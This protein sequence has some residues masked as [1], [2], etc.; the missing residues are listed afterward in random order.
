MA[1]DIV[2]GDS[3]NPLKPP[4]HMGLES[5]KPKCSKNTMLSSSDAPIFVDTT[6]WAPG[7]SKWPI[8]GE[9]VERVCPLESN[10]PSV[11]SWRRYSIIDM[12]ELNISTDVEFEDDGRRLEISAYDPERH[13]G[14][15]EC[16]A[17]NSLGSRKYSDSTVFYLQ[18]T[19]G[20]SWRI[21]EK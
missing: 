5:A 14:L 16:L 6:K 8:C 11:Y 2:G 19:D 20:K 15:Y 7:I 12:S 21:L 1:V 9:P 17:S 18:D 13:G 3:T 4:L 10:P